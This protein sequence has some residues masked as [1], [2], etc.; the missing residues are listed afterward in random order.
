MRGK[1]NEVSQM[2]Q[3]MKMKRLA[4]GRRIGGHCT[5]T[6][7]RDKDEVSEEDEASRI[8]GEN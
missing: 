4:D 7:G 5:V 2:A 3:G 1:G 8:R 6:G